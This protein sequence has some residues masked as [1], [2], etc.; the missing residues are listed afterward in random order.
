MRILICTTQV[1]FARGGAETLSEGLRD[2]LRARGHEAEVVA[3]PFSWTP[4]SD[5]LRGA[6]A[7]RLLDLSIVD[8]RPV[9]LLIA[10]KFPSYAVR[11]PRKVVWLVHQ[12]RQAYDWYGTP[13]SDWGAQ[14]GDTESRKALLRLDRRTLG[15]ARKLFAISRNVARRLRMGNGLRAEPL[16]PPSHLGSLLRPGPFEPFILS[17][18]RL[19]AAKRVDLLLRALG[20]SGS[21]L[22][23]V[24][25]GRGPE[26]ERLKRLAAELGL[27]ERVTFTGFLPDAD[28][29]ALYGHCRAV[30]YAPVDEDY[31]FSTVEAF[32]A[33][34]PVITTADAGGVL[35]FVEHE[36]SGLVTAAEPAAVAV[37]LRRLEDEAIAARLGAKNPRKV[38]GITWNNVVDRLLNP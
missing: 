21:A 5:I 14:A 38:A 4:R 22:R 32:A 28:V 2:A 12:H 15:E 37:S 3:L 7:W 30:F 27:G 34:K 23:V 29:A 10:T 6:L 1:P 13:L 9:D 17:V 8:G 19:D 35:E 11:H 24:I 31:G 25:A 36:V 16:Y 18:A 33:G 26:E 20:R